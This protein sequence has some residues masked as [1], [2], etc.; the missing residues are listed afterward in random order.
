MRNSIK[1]PVC[2]GSPHRLFTKEDFDILECN[3]CGHQ[4]V[5]ISDRT[6]HVEQVYSDTYFYGGGAGYTDYLA[7]GR[8]LRAAG[9]RYG[10]L[11]ARHTKP[12]KLLDVGSAAGYILKGLEDCGWQGV[13]VEPNASMVRHAEEALGLQMVTG[14]LENVELHEAFDAVSMLQVIGHFQDPREALETAAGFL[15]PG[16]HI[17]MDFWNTRSLTARIFGQHWHEYSPPSTLHWFSFDGLR[18]LGE[19]I[20]LVHVT[21][22]RSLKMLNGAHAKS[23]FKYKFS[24]VPMGA[25]AAKAIDLIPDN[26]P[27]IYPFDDLFWI[28]F[29]KPRTGHV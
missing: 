3:S 18:R 10:R 12:G 8:L 1:C 6:S 17:L 14:A 22:G 28:L 4:M 24:D 11:L 25:M 20:G 2:G 7:E 23:L 15:H 16:G 13:G 21:H 19:T 26:L 27:L 9:R 29:Q 5:E